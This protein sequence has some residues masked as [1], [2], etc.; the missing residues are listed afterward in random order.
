MFNYDRKTISLLLLLTFI[1]GIVF[2][3]YTIGAM[4]AIYI[5]PMMIAA[6]AA[7]FLAFAQTWFMKKF[8][9]G[10]ARSA[11][12]V[13]AG[14]SFIIIL[15]IAG[16][17][18]KIVNFAE[19]A[20]E[21][22]KSEQSIR[23]LEVLFKDTVDKAGERFNIPK[24]RI[25]Q[26]KIMA[27]DWRTLIYATAVSGKVAKGA[28]GKIGSFLTGFFGAGA[29]LVFQFFVMMY[30]I[31]AFLVSSKKIMAVISRFI[32]LSE[33]AKKDFFDDM[34]DT[35]RTMA[36]GMYLNGL[37]QGFLPAV[38]FVCTYLIW[39]GLLNIYYYLVIIAICTA[40]SMFSLPVSWFAVVFCAITAFLNDQYFAMAFLIAA[41]F[42][43][44][45]ADNIAKK[46]IGDSTGIPFVLTILIMVGA[47]AY[48][49]IVG[50]VLGVLLV[51]SGR[52]IWIETMK[53]YDYDSKAEKIPETPGLPSDGVNITEAALNDESE[54]IMTDAMPGMYE[55]GKIA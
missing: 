54:R 43:T 4:M 8:A 7:T 39:A 2:L 52:F 42:P 44:A 46:K 26:V 30:F 37:W 10:K 19:T 11:M 41:T 29:W 20:V 25:E 50:S 40:F 17:T 33:K 9:W 27:D 18:Y 6:F 13:L 23:H 3:Y 21:K 36:Y 24:E 22:A 45:G 51:K 49:G 15:P 38:I 34:A 53:I 1:A 16:G 31:Y 32:I 14:I 55:P 5:T 48:M 47:T 28:G 12:A 35:A